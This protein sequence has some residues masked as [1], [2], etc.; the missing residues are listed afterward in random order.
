MEE[1]IMST[2]ENEALIRQFFEIFNSV[3]GDMV[4]LKTAAWDSIFS[5]DYVI[6]FTT[7]DMNLEQFIQ[8]NAVIFTAF[9]DTYFTIDEM[10]VKEDKVVTR[11]TM[12]G[13]FKKEY[14]G[15]APTGKQIAIK[16]VSI[17]RIA[18]GRVVETWDYPDLLSVMIQLGVIPDLSS[19]I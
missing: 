1:I 9:P 13:T 3:Q 2:K 15:I 11:Y 7:R 16:G 8:Y 10:I 4:K 14:R 5:S 12:R 6:H 17:D 18:K 19:R